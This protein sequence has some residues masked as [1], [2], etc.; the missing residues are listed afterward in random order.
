MSGSR[1]RALTLGPMLHLAGDLLPHRDIDSRG[2]EISSGLLCLALLV[3][4]RG[5][6]DAA[7][8]GAVASSAPDV[9]HIVSSLRIGGRK[10]F[11]GWL[12]WHRSGPLPAEI[13]LVVAG[14]IIGALIAHRGK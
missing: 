2:F 6:F 4:R 8:I 10:V 11:H 14:A 5:L 1:L 9:E 12:G 7:T 13:Q 3:A